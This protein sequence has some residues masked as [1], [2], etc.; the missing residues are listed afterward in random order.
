MSMSVSRSRTTLAVVFAVCLV[1]S[2]LTPVAAQTRA[3][4]ARPS[5][6]AQCETTVEH[7]SFRTDNATVG[8]LSNGSAVSKTDNT[9]VKIEKADGFYKVHAKNPN[10][11]CVRFVVEVA[12]SAMPPA[13]IPGDV[14]SNDGNHSAQ[15]DSTY[16]WN[17]SETYTHVE[18]TLPASSS[19]TFAP[20]QVRVVGMSWASSTTTKAQSSWERLKARFSDSDVTK[21]TY[22]IT[23]DT[24]SV[25]TVPL[26][27]PDTDERVEEYHAVYSTDG[28]ESWVTVDTDTDDPV[29]YQETNGGDALQFTFN[30][31]DGDGDPDGQVR[32]T[33][34]PGLREDLRNQW[35]TYWGGKSTIGSWFG[36]ESNDADSDSDEEDDGLF[37]FLQIRIQM[38]IQMQMQTQIGTQVTA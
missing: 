27:N 24:S 2:G 17:A 18:F 11:Y 22:H 30:D 29:F 6:T 37:G 7:L 25:V 23:P 31:V 28:G 14:D 15:W 26:T 21:K 13:K 38:Q 1:A 3:A 36:A 34:N 19:A 20:N 16:D 35:D 10:A 32:F 8:E 4:D 9:R 5:M 33:A 12:E